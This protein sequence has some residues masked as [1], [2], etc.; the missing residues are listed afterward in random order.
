MGFIKAHKFVSL[1]VVTMAVFMA[2]MGG[3]LGIVSTR[4]Y[5]TNAAL[6][7][8]KAQAIEALPDDLM[9]RLKANLESGAAGCWK[10]PDG[11]VAAGV[12]K[13]YP[14]VSCDSVFPR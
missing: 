9:T 6:A 3:A 4:L 14:K 13:E 11:S 10:Y 12:T 1:G 7:Q 2:A 5:D 8:S